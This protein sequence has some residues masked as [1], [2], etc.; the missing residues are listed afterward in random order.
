MS[1]TFKHTFVLFKLLRPI[2]HS[3]LSWFLQGEA[4]FLLATD[5]AARGLDIQGVQTV[6]NYDAARTL[7]SHLHRIGRTA[8]AGQSGRAVTLAEDSDRPLIKE[9]ASRL[10]RRERGGGGGG[11]YKQL[12]LLLCSNMCKR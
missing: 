9:V 3:I 6:I 8:R 10:W 5:V 4:A 12:S 2:L 1:N 7:D 11:G